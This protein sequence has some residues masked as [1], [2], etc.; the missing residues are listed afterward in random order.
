MNNAPTYSPAT[1]AAFAAVDAICDQIIIAIRTGDGSLA[2]LND[3]HDAAERRLLANVWL[4][5]QT[6]AARAARQAS[7]NGARP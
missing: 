3:E 6:A 1:L 4:D 5:M 2:E 7:E